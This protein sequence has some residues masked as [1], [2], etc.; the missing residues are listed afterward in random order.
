ML[1]YYYHGEQWKLVFI[2]KDIPAYE[3]INKKEYTKE[4]KHIHESPSLLNTIIDAQTGKLLE[5]T[6]AVISF[7]IPETGVDENGT[8]QTFF[9]TDDSGTKVLIDDNLL[10]YTYYNSYNT[11]YSPLMPGKLVA[12]NGNAW[13]SAA[14]S[15]HVNACK[16]AEFL[17]SGLRRNSV[18]GAGMKIISSIQC[19]RIPG[20]NNWFNAVWLGNRNQMAYGQVK[21]AGKLK[22]LAAWLD[23]VAHEIFHGVT[24][25]SA[26]LEYHNQ[27]G[28]MNESYSDI[29]GVILSNINN[30]DIKTWNWELGEEISGVPIRNIKQPS[31]FGQPEHMKYYE[32]LPDTEDGDWG[33]CT[34]K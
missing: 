5:I 7:R 19:V 14:V 17:R 25:F 28:A 4:N 13:D 15:A 6:P 1:Y 27:S 24:Q 11:F 12:K 23:V 20:N 9:A 10:V 18:D 2:L 3:K 16:V 26:R 8:T 34:Y 21:V 31:L 22:S 33:V 29:F 32:N 30:H